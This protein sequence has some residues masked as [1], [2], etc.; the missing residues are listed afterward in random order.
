MLR[1][2]SRSAGPSELLWPDRYAPEAA[3][4]PKLPVPERNFSVMI[5]PSNPAFAGDLAGGLFEPIKLRS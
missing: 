4:K 3:L 1:S 5:A 2:S